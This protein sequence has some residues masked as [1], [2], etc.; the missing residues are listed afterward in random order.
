MRMTP[1]QY[2]NS[3]HID[4]MVSRLFYIYNGNPNVPQN[5]L[6]KP[7]LEEDTNAF[8]YIDTIHVEH[9]SF[10]IYV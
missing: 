10:L 4:E 3:Y 5:G 8:A 1:Y 9:S 6:T 2:R 7:G